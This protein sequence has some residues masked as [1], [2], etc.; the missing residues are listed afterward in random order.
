MGMIAS[1]ELMKEVRT[2]AGTLVDGNGAMVST[3]PAVP[4]L[5]SENNIAAAADRDTGADF[6]SREFFDRAWSNF[7]GGELTSFA[8]TLKEKADRSYTVEVYQANASH[9]NGACSECNSEVGWSLVCKSWDC[10]VHTNARV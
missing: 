1:V 4:S 5:M 9:A 8:L 3:R 2:D 7:S 10:A 6:T